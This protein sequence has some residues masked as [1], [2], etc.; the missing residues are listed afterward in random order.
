MIDEQISFD[1]PQPWE[2]LKFEVDKI[3]AI[4]FLVGPNGSGKSRFADELYRHVKQRPG[5]ARLLGTDRLSGME[6]SSAMRDISGDTFG[7]G[8]DENRFDSLKT[9]GLERG[10]G[11]DTF[12]LLEE[13]VDLHVQIEA[14]LSHLFEVGLRAPDA[15][16]RASTGRSAVST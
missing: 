2:N 8:F 4:N 5:G 6:H 3:G 7:R 16:G 14:T 15:N 9:A 10:S 12:V 1:L 11:I 13:R